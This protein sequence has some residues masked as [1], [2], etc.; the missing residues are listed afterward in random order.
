[1]WSRQHV[2][3]EL[4]ERKRGR[5]LCTPGLIVVNT[6]PPP[7]QP[8]SQ[9]II[10]VFG[11]FI[12][13]S[14]CGAL[15]VAIPKEAQVF[16]D[17]I[18]SDALSYS[19]SALE[20][21]A[22]NETQFKTWSLVKN[23]SSQS[24]G[25]VNKSQ[26]EYGIEDNR[27]PSG[28][29]GSPRKLKLKQ[30]QQQQHHYE[31]QPSAKWPNHRNNRPTKKSSHFSPSPVAVSPFP[32]PI[33][34]SINPSLVSDI[35][36]QFGG[37]HPLLFDTSPLPGNHGGAFNPS[38]FR[39]STITP[40][41]PVSG[42]G[43]VNGL[44]S[45]PP[46]RIVLSSGISVGGD[47]NK[48]PG[49]FK[50]LGRLKKGKPARMRF[51]KGKLRP[52]G[53]DHFN[54]GVQQALHVPRPATATTQDPFP[55]L[56]PGYSRVTQNLP[57]SLPAVVY[58]TTNHLDDRDQVNG[59]GNSWIPILGPVGR[60]GGKGKK[61]VNLTRILKNKGR[62]RHRYSSNY[63]SLKVR[64]HRLAG[65]LSQNQKGTGDVIAVYPNNSKNYNTVTARSRALS[66]TTT[67]EAPEQPATTI[68]WVGGETKT[69]TTTESE[70]IHARITKIPNLRPVDVVV[71]NVTTQF[72]EVLDERV[73]AR[74]K[75]I[76]KIVRRLP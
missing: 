34:S 35:Y 64:S 62:P 74:L 44:F 27:W 55:N 25:P 72:P 20:F 21:G 3:S 10:R 5:I 16:R 7:S 57:N 36:P 31:Q 46:S 47:D 54:T 29:G 51:R 68:S 76:R 37:F 1:M 50:E 59:T 70:V 12:L 17:K 58:G 32:Q 9:L 33:R 48:K 24:G 8:L 56:S 23:L 40:L 13:W 69:T 60:T 4:S 43:G 52:V 42:S 18:I 28:G 61:S 49:G 63:S 66:T 15:R 11:L 39:S 67:T 45:D 6:V 38:Q 71:L 53:L 75:A 26:Y 65:I 30:Q 14:G 41:R 19:Y 73:R 2:A 22:S